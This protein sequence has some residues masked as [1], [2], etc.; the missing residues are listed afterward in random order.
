VAVR[1]VVGAAA[2]LHGKEEADEGG[3][4]EEGS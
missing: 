3:D 2:P 4:D 1:P